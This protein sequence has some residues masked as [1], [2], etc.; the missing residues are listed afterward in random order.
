MVGVQV[1]HASPTSRPKA[2]KGR[3]HPSQV[4]VTTAPPIDVTVLRPSNLP[5]FR[6]QSTYRDMVLTISQSAG[7]RERGNNTL[8]SSL[9][10]SI[11][12]LPSR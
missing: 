9:L 12:L 4:R 10:V 1:T 6:T 7:D 5:P 8:A 11:T 2:H 3:I